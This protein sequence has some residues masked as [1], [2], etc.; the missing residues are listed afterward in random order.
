MN[1]ISKN[2]LMTALERVYKIMNPT[3]TYKWPLLCDR[4][5]HEIWLKHENHTPTGAFKIR[6]GINYLN[7]LLIHKPNTKTIVT[8]STGNHGQSITTAASLMGINSI[9]VCPK[10]TSK[11]KV[12]AMVSQGA[13]IKFKGRDFQ[14]SVEYA[15]NFSSEN[16]FHFIYS[17]HKWLVAGVA[18]YAWEMFKI[19]EPDIVYVPIG[20]GSGCIGIISVKKILNLKTKIIGVQAQG[21][22]SYALSFAAKKLINTPS[23]NTTAEGLATRSPNP[24]ALRII[25]EEIYD[26]ITV[27]DEEITEAQN[28]LL[29]DTHSLAEPAGAAG[30]AATIKHNR[31]KSTSLTVLSGSNT[32]VNIN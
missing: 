18:T 4:L 27:T 32:D 2:D 14:E 26:I 29:E 31:D 8:A 22:P 15:I 23:I 6:G 24:D 10:N 1:C 5:K 13:N 9:I 16:N 12:R 21:A 19:I 20:L 11:G 28:I 30:L 7:E 3:P 17:F 25:N